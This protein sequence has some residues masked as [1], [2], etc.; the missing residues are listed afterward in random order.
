MLNVGPQPLI[1]YLPR[2]LGVH[3]HWFLG[4]PTVNLLRWLNPY[5]DVL[6]AQASRD[7][8]TVM[9]DDVD[10]G[11]AGEESDEVPVTSRLKPNPEH[12]ESDV[13]L[14]D[15]RTCHIRPVRPDDGPALD[16][17]SQELSD[18]TLYTRF[19]TVSRELAAQD[20]A[21]LLAADNQNRVSLL[22]MSR[23]KVIGVAVYDAVAR[24]EGEIAFTIA[25]AHQGRGLGSV[26]LEHLAAVAR[27]NGIH[28]FKA[29]VLPANKRMLNTFEAAGYTPSQEVQDGIV[30]LDFDIDPTHRTRGVARGREHRAEALSIQRLVAP[31]AVAVMCDQAAEDSLGA[32]IVGNL[33]AGGFAGHIYVVS[34]GGD[35][36]GDIGG[37]TSLTEIGEPVDLVIMAMGAS[38]VEK[39]VNDCADMDVIGIIVATG[40]FI[41]DHDSRRQKALAQSIREKGIR[42]VGPNSLGIINTAPGLTLNA[43]VIPSMPGRGRVGFF[44]QTAAFGTAILSEAA[45][46]GLGVSVFFSA[47]NRADV[48]A[49]DLMQY[50]EDDDSTS[51]VL[52][53]LES[54]GNP[55][56]FTRIARRLA[57]RKPVVAVRS[58][59][60]SQALPLGHAVRSTD[61][62]A[63]AV[64]AMFEQAGVIQVNSLTEL[65]DLADLL[66]VQPLPVGGTVGFVTDSDS[67]GVLSVDAATSLGLEPIGPAR[68]TDPTLHLDGF[69]KT[70]A[71]V[72][73]DPAVDS[74][75]VTHV[76]SIHESS[77]ALSEVMTR[78]AKTATKPLIAVMLANRSG[79]LVGDLTTY[80]MPGHGSVPVFGDV[81][82]ALR[83]LRAVVD[84]QAWLASPRGSIPSW[85]DVDSH[86]GHQVALDAVQK[87]ESPQIRS[88]LSVEDLDTILDSYGIHLWPTIAVQTEEEAVAAAESIGYPVVLKSTIGRYEHRTDLGG[89]RLTLENEHAV[90]TAY[91]SMMATLP[92][93]AAARLAIQR[94]APA[95]VACVAG[96]TEDPLFGPVV[97]FRLGG[98]YPIL[99]NDT[100]YRIPPLTDEDAKELVRS[101]QSAAMLLS[102][103]L[104]DGQRSAELD[105]AALEDI[106]TRLGHLA[107]DLPE[108]AALELNPIVV[109]QKG[110]AVLGAR[111]FVARPLARTDLEAR[112]LL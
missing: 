70:V 80:G 91:L 93:D 6:T 47:G 64:D 87:I 61:L 74:V 35:S 100:V 50:W 51:L 15:G 13:V 33:L 46:R 21:R 68:I 104:P 82:S 53:Y 72:L 30:L 67:L 107:D 39:A 88:E 54:I 96:T 12:W 7:S 20:M 97:S 31:Q 71:E 90:R 60:S 40:G 29:E 22:A 41:A 75:I 66:A 1:L 49:N 8:V 43:S 16:S 99:L 58:G 110:A 10:P 112:R 25:D 102:E 34:P 26:L 106:L 109:H 23:G 5:P 63:A 62:E 85:S 95:G 73:A 28:R 32:A 37:F 44:S 24:A 55:R 18:E 3:R 105:V 78:L 42:L 101:P 92:A 38:A 77:A 65:L 108:I 98:L 2:Q 103:R 57:R 94:M 19:F 86:R 17:F 59:R 76:P 81:E 45:A 14:R 4:S 36:V 27:E 56:K 69:E 83:A 79:P 48:S 9:S 11:I 52:L 89:L 111:G 84:Y